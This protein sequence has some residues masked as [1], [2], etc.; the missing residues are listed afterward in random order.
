VTTWKFSDFRLNVSFL[1]LT[2]ADRDLRFSLNDTSL[3]SVESSQNSIKTKDFGFWRCSQANKRPPHTATWVSTCYFKHWIEYLADWSQRHELWETQLEHTTPKEGRTF[4]A[5][6]HKGITEHTSIPTLAENLEF[7]ADSLH[8]TD[9]RTLP[10]RRQH[11]QWHH[12]RGFMSSALSCWGI[13]DLSSRNWRTEEQNWLQMLSSRPW[14]SRHRYLTAT[15]FFRRHQRLAEFLNKQKSDSLELEVQTI[16]TNC[17]LISRDVCFNDGFWFS[18]WLE[19]DLGPQGS[20]FLS[21]ILRHTLYRVCALAQN[22]SGDTAQF[23][24]QNSQGDQEFE[25]V[26]FRSNGITERGPFH[27]TVFGQNVC[28]FSLELR[29]P[30]C[31]W[32]GE[33][34]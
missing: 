8:G 31:N 25:G 16:D 18:I 29:H 23:A 1:T 32:K 15:K 3:E 11:V 10:L 30:V 7:F 27:F 5:L 33:K 28:S 2:G 12:L 20:L 4:T 17:Q 34:H 26:V 19:T 14:F 22:W 21:W 24:C 9:L 6:I 13:W